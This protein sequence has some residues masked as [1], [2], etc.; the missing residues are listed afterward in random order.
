[1]GEFQGRVRERSTMSAARWLSL[2]LHK[3]STVGADDRRS[4]GQKGEKSFL[5]Y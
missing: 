3:P 1:M 2:S 4:N 5:Q